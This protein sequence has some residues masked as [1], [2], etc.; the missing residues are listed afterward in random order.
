MDSKQA[1]DALIE[2]AHSYDL[3]QD[4]TPGLNEDVV[5]RLVSLTRVLLT[6]LLQRPPTEEEINDVIPR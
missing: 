5:D 3:V 4:N 2:F 1:R 6:E